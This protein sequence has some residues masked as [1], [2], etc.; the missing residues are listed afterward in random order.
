MELDKALQTIKSVCDDSVSNGRFR[1]IDEVSV[2]NHAFNL[3]VE[4]CNY[5]VS[6]ANL[7]K[8]TALKVEPSDALMQEELGD[9][10][11]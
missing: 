1:N 10:S 4:A 2:V 8:E 11:N 7:S 9:K 6:Q 3:I 5:A